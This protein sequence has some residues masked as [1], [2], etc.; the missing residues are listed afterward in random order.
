MR[1]SSIAVSASMIAILAV[2][3]AE[4]RPSFGASANRAGGAAAASAKASDSATLIETVAA[5]LGFTINAKATPS[6]GAE[7]PRA[8]APRA[9]ECEEEKKR[10]QAAKA[11][12][13]QRTAEAGK[14]AQRG[15]D[16]VYLAF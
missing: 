14:P 7:A 8:A 5:L 13:S 12:D 2:S 16:P 10:A 6:A 11:S 4:A 1:K 9:E 15:R 3:A